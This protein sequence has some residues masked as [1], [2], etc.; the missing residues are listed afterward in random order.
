[1]T[2]YLFILGTPRRRFAGAE[3][4]SR[5][6]QGT[7]ISHCDRVR[8][9]EYAPRDPC[10]VLER[11]HGLTK[12]VERGARVPVER[13]RISPSRPERVLMILAENASRYG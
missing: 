2:V 9:T 1:M 4:G 7:L 5:V 3:D 11:R 10:S 12:I 6:S 13:H 8:A